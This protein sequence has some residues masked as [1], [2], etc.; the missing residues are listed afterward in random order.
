MK[1][2][3]KKWLPF[4]KADIEAAQTLLAKKSRSRW[5]NILALWHCQQAIEKLLKAIIVEKSGE[6]FKIHDLG[7]LQELAKINLSEKELKMVLTLSNYYLKS[8]YPDLIYKSLPDPDAKKAKS[9]FKE[10]KKLY[11]WLLEYLEKM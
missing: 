5:S 7:R 4:A 11:L 8:R 3:T 9:I 2:V 1:A 10:T 6:V